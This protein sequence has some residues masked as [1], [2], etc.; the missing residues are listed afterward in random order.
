MVGETVG[1]KLGKQS[2]CG[3]L[4]VVLVDRT[5]LME[6]QNSVEEK[7]FFLYNQTVSK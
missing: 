4:R 6:S 3:E 5:D 2:I 1:E 7:S